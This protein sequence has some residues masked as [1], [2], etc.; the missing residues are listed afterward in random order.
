MAAQVFQPLNTAYGQEI[1]TRNSPALLPAINATPPQ[2][3][4]SQAP[5]F[6]LLDGAHVSPMDLIIDPA[7]AEILM[8]L[9]SL[10][11][12]RQDLRPKEWKIDCRVPVAREVMKALQNAVYTE[13]FYVFSMNPIVGKVLLVVSPLRHL[14]AQLITST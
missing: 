3:S 4:T 5:Q 9:P 12:I 13:V 1:L 11:P 2:G 14:M 8:K 7:I 10:K 6:I